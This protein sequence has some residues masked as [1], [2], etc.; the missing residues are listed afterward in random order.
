MSYSFRTHDIKQALGVVQSGRVV[1]FPTGTSYGLAV[2]ALQGFALQRLRNLK[3]RPEEKTFT[4]FLATKNWDTYLQLTADERQFLKKWANQPLTLLV[5]PTAMLAHLAENGLIGVRVIDHP[6]M[7]E[8]A[9]AVTVPLTATSAN[10]SGHEAC[11]SPECIEQKFTGKVDE[12]TYDLSLGCIL[13]A[14]ELPPSQPST[15]AKLTPTGVDIIRPGELL[16]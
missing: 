4:I 14:G 10:I 7:A 6:I 12:T 2:D 1:A 16:L 9:N 11:F 5:T 8:L 13:E 3:Q 15:I